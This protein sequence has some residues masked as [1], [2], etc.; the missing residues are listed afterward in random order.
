MATAAS[1]LKGLDKIIREDLM[2]Q[3]RVLEP[4]VDGIFSKMYDT[5]EGVVAGGGRVGT[6]TGGFT[7]IH[8][9]ATGVAGAFRNLAAGGDNDIDPDITGQSIMYSPSVTFPSATD[10]T[11]PGYV[12][13][14][15]TLIEGLGVFALP[16]H[17]IM[18]EQL[19]ATIAKPVSLTIKGTAKNVA[20][21]EAN[22][23]YATDGTN[24][25]LCT[26]VKDAD[27]TSN[28]S[29]T[30][31]TG[32]STDDTMNI[33]FGTV[34]DVI[35][36][37]G[38]F[39][40]G[41]TCDIF[42]SDFTAKRVTGSLICTNVDYV[43][44]V[45]MLTSLT[46]VNLKTLGSF[47][48]NDVVI[49]W[50]SANDTDNVAFGPSGIDKWTVNDNASIFG[51]DQTKHSQFNSV[52][53]AVNNVLDQAVLDTNVG[54]FFDAYSDMCDLDSF[55]TT[56]GV[57]NNYIANT[58]GLWRY[59]RHNTGALKLKEGWTSF[60]YTYQ[61]RDFELLQ[62]RY[63]SN[64]ILYGCKLADQNL[65]RYVP[66]RIPSAGKRSEF[67]P[68]IQWLGPIVGSNS[69]FLPA[70]NSSAKLTRFVEAPFFCQREVCPEQLQGIKLTGLTELFA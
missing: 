48:A 6:T 13:K 33:A 23:F 34:A 63:V 57:I 38:R 49:L 3:E 24:I 8:T 64:G 68:E 59:E 42:K 69:I 22:N 28:P 51:I 21:S 35:G 66:P 10:A 25:A 67:A 2:F 32:N 65:K 55:I 50:D 36:R 18:A 30:Y 19:D 27:S 1:T 61:G 56:A 44:R 16:L 12:Q 52:V 29:V 40:P 15:I 54:A 45:A 5:S 47:E 20:Q 39:Y 43:D 26:L 53:S 31:T 7:V 37:V 14:T 58:D 11:A 41:M 46:G 60:D 4:R 62:S 9:F 17:L 70:R